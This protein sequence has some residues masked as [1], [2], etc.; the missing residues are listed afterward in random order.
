MS[1][2]LVPI[3]NNF[4]VMGLTPTVVTTLVTPRATSFSKEYKEVNKLYV[5]PTEWI[6]GGRP[7]YRR[8]PA[9]SETYQVDFFADGF[10]GYTLI[11]YGA[12]Q[13]GA[14]SMYVAV[15]ED[16]RSLL[17]YDGAIVWKEG[18]TPVLKAIVNFEEIGLI[19]GRF[20]VAYQ[21]IYDDAPE[22]L[23]FAVTDYSLAGLDFNV[24]DSASFVFQSTVTPNANAWPF[25]GKYAFAPAGGNLSWKNYIDIVNRVPQANS[26]VQPGIPSEYQP[27][28]AFL[29]WSSPLPWKLDSIV[30]RTSLTSNL[31]DASLYYKENG[32]W[33]LVQTTKV[34]EDING[35]FWNFQTDNSPQNEWKVE[36]PDY[37]KIEVKDITVSGVLFVNTKPSTARTRAQ[38]S[39]Y[40]TN[41][42]PKDEKFC[43]LAI[44]NVNDFEIQKNS[45]GE[46]LVED[47]RNISNRDYE[48]VANWLT[49]Y[50]DERLINILEKTKTYTPG[51]LAPP[52]L[53]KASYF[54]LEE[55]GIKIANEPP[56][57]PPS[58]PEVIETLL[59]G[60]SVSFYPSLGLGT[61]VGAT[62]SFSPIP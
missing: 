3:A 32:D 34:S 28:L 27:L 20:L 47:I 21:Q 41:L 22:P 44:I 52:T 10:I 25:P 50:W 55:F 49:T 51:F 26:G 29:S 6:P 57:Y 8:L 1:Q 45:R 2:E 13:F 16:L 5:T 46:L 14:G 15:S 59:L 18:T 31:P 33:Q 37:S 35:F 36:W 42:V 58:P 61:L 7:I 17:I 56:P 38:L 23:P 19:S 60:A 30:L 24:I 62:V 39:I 43:R 40:P 53:L 12:D 4:G 54:D 48:P 9:V 11:P